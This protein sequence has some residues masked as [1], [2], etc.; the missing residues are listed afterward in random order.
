MEP[1]KIKFAVKQ[2]TVNEICAFF[3]LNDSDYFEKLSD[4]IDIDVYSKK[5]HDHTIQFTLFDNELLV[6]LSPCYFNYIEEK[7]GYISS[8]TIRKGYRHLNLGS[9]MIKHIK[10]YAITKGFN[11]IA[12]QAHCENSLNVS[13]YIKNGF[14]LFHKNR[15]ACV[16]KY[17]ASS[18]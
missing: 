15:T 13:F 17:Q 12:V 2:L 1:R 7:T 10:G 5:V 6:G 11:A 8:L 18:N 4:R 16:Y 9:E 3:T 14:K